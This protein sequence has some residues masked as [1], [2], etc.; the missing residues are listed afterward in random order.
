MY[1]VIRDSAM[2]LNHHGDVT[3][4]FANNMRLYEATGVRT[5]LITDWKENLVE[6]FEPGE[7]V[8]AYRSTEECSEQIDY[9]LRHPEEAERI[10]WAGQQRT[11]REHTY[12]HRMEELV[13][14]VAE[15][16]N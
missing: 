12:R 2:T 4:G 11:L 7:E 16:L 3:P 13:E 6:M 14:L 9:H 10:A 1:Q 15:Y 5:L 8:I